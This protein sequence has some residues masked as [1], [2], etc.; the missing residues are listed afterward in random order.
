MADYSIILDCNA[1]AQQTYT[2]LLVH[3]EL[4]SDSIDD[5]NSIFTFPVFHLTFKHCQAHIFLWTTKFQSGQINPVS[6]LH[7]VN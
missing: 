4:M 1:T 2:N 5:Q 3:L 6:Y 7:F